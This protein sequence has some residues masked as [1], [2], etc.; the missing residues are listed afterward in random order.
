MDDLDK[1]KKAAL[2]LLSFRPRS[3]SELRKRLTQKKLPAESIERTVEFLYQQRM[4]DDEKFARLYALSRLQSRAS[5]KGLVQRELA[6]KGVSA[7]ATARA[8]EAVEDISEQDMAMEL[9]KRRLAS[10]DRK[11]AV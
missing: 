4:L 11:S 1:T 10:I 7:A 5:G 8:M 2:R 3:E 6:Q 9:A